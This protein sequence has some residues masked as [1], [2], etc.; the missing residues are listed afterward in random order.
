MET[1][2]FLNFLLLF[3]FRRVTAQ[4]HKKLRETLLIKDNAFLYVFRLKQI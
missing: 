1:R 4:K 3:Q 2:S